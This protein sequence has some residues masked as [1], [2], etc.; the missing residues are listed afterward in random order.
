VTSTYIEGFVDVG[1]HL[2]CQIADNFAKGNGV[3]YTCVEPDDSARR[4]KKETFAFGRCRGIRGSVFLSFQAPHLMSLCS[5]CLTWLSLS[6]TDRSAATE[7]KIQS[8]NTGIHVS[9]ILE[10]PQEYL[11]SVRLDA[12]GIT[13]EPRPSNFIYGN[14][15]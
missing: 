5:A 14:P 1:G 2:L 11:T 6:L 9:S 13:S 10:R 4:K 8:H 15:E 7:R 12:A 3:R